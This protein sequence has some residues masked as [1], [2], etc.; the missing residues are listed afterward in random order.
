[1]YNAEVLSK[2][3]VVQHFPFG[4]LFSWDT[5]PNAPPP[6]PSSTSIHATSQP[7]SL[8]HSV[9]QSTSTGKVTPVRSTPVEGTKVP[10]AS[11]ATAMPSATAHGPPRGLSANLRPSSSSTSSTA[12]DRSPG[13]R[14]P[15]VSRQA[16]A[17]SNGADSMLPPTRAPW[18]KGD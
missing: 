13:I 4:S 15:D 3:P 2:F 7:F 17:N 6:P 18:A 9:G 12:P 5:D 11:S 1:M 16:A 10:W 8:N 14:P